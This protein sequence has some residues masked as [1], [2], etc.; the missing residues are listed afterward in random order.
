MAIDLTSV[1]KFPHYKTASISHT[2]C[3]EIKLPR[4]CR[5]I[6]IGSESQKLY[7]AQNNAV[8]GQP[9]PSDKFF[10]PKDN[11]KSI[12]IGQGAERVDSIFVQLSGGSGDI[13]I[14][15]SER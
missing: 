13:H 14:E 15:L 11:A 5:R 6:E 3:T 7:I 1:T 9:I 12:S 10:I 8:D 2:T 4:N